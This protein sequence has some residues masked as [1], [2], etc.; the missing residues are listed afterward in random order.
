MTNDGE[1]E[2]A[3]TTHGRL[4]TR[5]EQEPED[6]R[7]ANSPAV[8]GFF[9]LFSVVGIAL[10]GLPFYYD[11]MVREFGWTRAQVASGNAFSK[12]IVGPVFGFLAG[13]MVDRFGPRKL[14]IL[15]ILM[16]GLAVAGLG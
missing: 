7:A 11:F 1:I 4:M 6:R 16:A 10:W 2:V 12:L 3:E 5:L 9:A 14:L 15:G 13:W 8:T